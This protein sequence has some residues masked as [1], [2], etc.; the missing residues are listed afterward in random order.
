MSFVI[1]LAAL[2]FLMFVAY[3]GYSVIMFA[4]VAALLAT[5]LVSATAFFS[6]L[7]GDQKIRSEC[8]RFPAAPTPARVKLKLY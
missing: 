8:F 4:P 1:T 3:R 7:V 6:T 5:G 2:F